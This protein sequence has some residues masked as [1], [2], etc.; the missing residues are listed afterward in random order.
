MALQTVAAAAGVGIAAG[1]W[2]RSL[3]F[4]H[5]VDFRAPLRSRC[6]QC[7]YLVVPIAV[8]GL[9]A[10]AALDGRC[11]ACR[12]LLGLPAGSVELLAAACLAVLALS[13]WVLAAW[14]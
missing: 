6:P 14:S 9:A 11:P 4:A 5:S 1:P 2:L 3:V 7:R 8:R 12:R 10:V 13:V